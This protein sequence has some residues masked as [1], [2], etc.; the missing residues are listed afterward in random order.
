MCGVLFTLLQVTSLA[1]CDAEDPDLAGFF[2]SGGQVGG[3][4]RCNE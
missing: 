1:W 3:A 2:V 4:Y